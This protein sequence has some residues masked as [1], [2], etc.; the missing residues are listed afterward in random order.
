MGVGWIVIGSVAWWLRA[1][2]GAREGEGCSSERE[3]E[4]LKER[5]AEAGA[6]LLAEGTRSPVS[7]PSCSVTA[8]FSPASLFVLAPTRVHLLLFPRSLAPGYRH[9]GCVSISYE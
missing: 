9:Q 3:T 6:L 4:R 2:A 1:S 8:R 5:E 7:V